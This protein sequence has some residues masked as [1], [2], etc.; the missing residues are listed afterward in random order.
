MDSVY[1]N[2]EIA[3]AATDD[4][5]LKKL[6]IGLAWNFFESNAIGLVAAGEVTKPL[7]EIADRCNGTF[8]GDSDENELTFAAGLEVNLLRLAA[9]R[10]GR[11]WGDIS[12]RPSNSDGGFLRIPISGRSCR[13]EYDISYTTIGFSIGPPDL[14]FSYAKILYDDNTILRDRQ[15]YTAATVLDKLPWLGKAK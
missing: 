1:V 14:R 10:I 13:S 15:I 11:H 2:P 8:V 12:L 4:Y 5:L 7:N 9:I 6:R 3:G